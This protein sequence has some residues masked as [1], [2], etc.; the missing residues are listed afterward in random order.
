MKEYSLKEIIK[1]FEVYGNNKI[2]SRYI[3]Q[4][5][6]K[7]IYGVPIF[8]ID[9]LGS[10]ITKSQTLALELIN[11]AQEEAIYLSQ[12]VLPETYVSEFLLFQ[13]L[14]YSEFTLITEKCVP[15]MAIKLEDVDNFLKLCLQTDKDHYKACAFK[16]LCLLL[17]SGKLDR[18]YI[19]K[20][21]VYIH[22]TI[23]DESNRTKHQMN[24][25]LCGCAI[26]DDSD[27]KTES[28]AISYNIDYSVKYYSEYVNFVSSKKYIENAINSRTENKLDL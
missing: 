3:K 9:N 28:Y 7:T 24:N 19:N 27:I 10:T 23:S 1:I 17:K 16:T 11:T 13:M 4:G 15:N 6:D 14:K 8:F 21:L 2:R 25:F 26:Y 5:A 12:Y 18:D 22:Y 20:L